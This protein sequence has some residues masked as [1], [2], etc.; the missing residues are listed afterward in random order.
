YPLPESQLDR[1]F[2]RI[3]LGYPDQLKE[4]E[5]IRNQEFEHP[6][7]KVHP[8]LDKSELILLQEQIKNVL[9]EEEILSYLLRIVDATRT[10]PLLSLVCSPRGSLFMYRAAQAYAFLQAR[11]GQ[12][13]ADNNTHELPKPFMVIAPHKPLEHYGTYPLPESQLDRF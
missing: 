1:F 12:A 5:I 13:S 2:M 11:E 4:R 9:V 10:S 7:H 8:V 6:L 3:R